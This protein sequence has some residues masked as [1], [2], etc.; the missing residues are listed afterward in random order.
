MGTGFSAITNLNHQGVG[1]RCGAFVTVLLYYGVT[2]ELPLLQTDVEDTLEKARQVMEYASDSR[3]RPR[4]YSRSE[5]TKKVTEQAYQKQEI[6]KHLEVIR[7]L[8]KVLGCH[9]KAK[10]IDWKFDKQVSWEKL[11]KEEKGQCFQEAIRL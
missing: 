1:C 6:I 9:D 4:A 7:A 5:D 10:R 3:H 11:N 2:L 8:A